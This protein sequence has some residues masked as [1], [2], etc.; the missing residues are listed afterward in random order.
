MYPP[1]LVQFLG[2]SRILAFEMDLRDFILKIY[3]YYYFNMAEK[4]GLF[5]VIY[6]F[7]IISSLNDNIS[8]I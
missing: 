8:A 5:T 1:I 7:I 3:C 6:K 4:W 2:A